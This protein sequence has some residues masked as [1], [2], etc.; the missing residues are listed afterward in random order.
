MEPYTIVWKGDEALGAKVHAFVS[1]LVQSDY[2]TTVVTEYAGKLRFGCQAQ[3]ERLL[4][5]QDVLA[6]C[7]AELGQPFDDFAKPLLR[8]VV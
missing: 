6:E 1:W 2:W 5:G 4:V 8:H 3:H 7:G